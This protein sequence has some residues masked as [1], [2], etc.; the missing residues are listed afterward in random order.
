MFLSGTVGTG[1][2]HLIAAM[3]D[4]LARIKKE[5]VNY[6]NSVSLLNKIRFTF[7]RKY[8]D[9]PTTEEITNQIKDCNLLIIDDLGS[10]KITD[11]ASEIFFD[12]IDY[13]Y[14]NLK[15]TIISTNLTSMEIKE[16]L[17]ERL[18]SRIYEMCK[19]IK[20]TGKD[21]RLFN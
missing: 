16:K 11:W 20:L 21:Y 8:K 12:I 4:Y 14:S 7:N 6:Y 9:E 15:S 5:H 13:R 2:T 17:N 18:M 10:E 1:K 3:I 19:G